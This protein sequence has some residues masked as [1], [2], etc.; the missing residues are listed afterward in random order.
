MVPTKEDKSPAQII[1]EIVTR[2][3]DDTVYCLATEKKFGWQTPIGII[4]KEEA[5]NRDFSVRLSNKNKAGNFCNLEVLGHN[6]NPIAGNMSL[7]ISKFLPD[8]VTN[9]SD[10][11]QSCSNIH[12][13][14]EIPDY[15]GKHIIQE[16]F[17]DVNDNLIGYVLFNYTDNYYRVKD[18]YFGPN[19]LPIIIAE[20]ETAPYGIQLNSIYDKNG[21]DSILFLTSGNDV[22]PNKDGAYYWQRIISDDGKGFTEK[23]IRS[24]DINHL[25]MIDEY[26]NCGAYVIMD[27]F[28]NDSISTF[29]DINDNPIT[30]PE[31]SY[32]KN[33]INVSSIK[34]TYDYNLYKLKSFEF[35]DINGERCENILGT[36]KVMIEYDSLGNETKRQGVNLDNKLSPIDDNGV[37]KYTVVWDTIGN[38]IEYHQYDFNNKPV[39]KNGNNSSYYNVYDPDTK[40]IVSKT[41]YEYNDSTNCEDI[42]YSFKYSSRVDSLLYSDKSSKVVN[43]DSLGRVT[44]TRFFDKLGNRDSNTYCAIDS[45]E[46]IL[47]LKENINK[48]IN[49]EFR[50]NGSLQSEIIIDS[51]LYTKTLFSYDES[52]H[53]TDSYQ[54]RYT[55]SWSLI[56]QTDC[57]ELGI[58]SRAGGNAGV[59]CLH[60]NISQIID[61]SLNSFEILDEFNEP[62]YLINFMGDYEIYSSFGKNESRYQARILRDEFGK[63]ITQSDFQSLRNKLPKAMSIEVVDTSAYK[64]GIRDN[65]LILCFGDYTVDLNEP[66]TESNFKFEWTVR[67]VID[68][69]KARDMVVFRVEDGKAN[70]YGLDTIAGLHGTPSEL[71]FIP[72]VR[73]LTERQTQRILE[74]LP[75][76]FPHHVDVEKPNYAIISFPEMYRSNRYTTYAENVK[77]ASILLGGYDSTRSFRYDYK[78]G[79][80]IDDLLKMTKPLKN[81]KV[82]SNLNLNYFFTKNGTNLECIHSDKCFIG[83]YLINGYITDSDWE[84]LKKLYSNTAD[85][86]KKL[87]SNVAIIDLK[88][89]EGYWEF[90]EN[91]LSSFPVAGSIRFDEDGNCLGIMTGYSYVPETK[92]KENYGSPIF[93]IDKSFNGTWEKHGNFISLN[94]NR[95]RRESIECVAMENP[96]NLEI[97]A[98]VKYFNEDYSKY[99]NYYDKRLS[100]YCGINDEFFIKSINK[101]QMVIDDGCGNEYTL[102]KAKINPQTSIPEFKGV[103]QSDLIGNWSMTESNLTISMNFMDNQSLYC[104]LLMDLPLSETGNKIGAFV[105]LGISGNYEIKDDLAYLKFDESSVVKDF[106][107]MKG[108]ISEDELNEKLSNFDEGLNNGCQDF[109]KLLIESNLSV[110]KIIDGVMYIDDMTLNRINDNFD[111]VVGEITGSEGYFVDLGLTGKFIILDWCDWNCTMDIDAFS[112]ELEKQKDNPKRITLLP[113]GVDENGNDIFGT[114]FT[115]DCPSEKLGIHITSLNVPSIYYLGTIMSRYKIMQ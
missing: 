111:V 83:M 63:E 7:T 15:S 36:H 69:S 5:R 104:L 2:H 16:R 67:N 58:P 10:Y 41:G 50:A 93:K 11:L 62:D 105:S 94:C 68:A 55:N 18:S 103:A 78:D 106:S 115:L 32:D 6:L 19:G 49:R 1:E 52:G 110:S 56:G 34:S 100:A 30:L 65:D 107:Y 48:T 87:E 71:G 95:E 57:S 91:E 85:E 70:V 37:S 73:Y 61:G 22:V 9:S 64:L 98:A 23:I 80:K 59:R 72:H 66:L 54:H 12:R 26:G 3:K 8:S 108:E 89:L 24:L 21:N 31:T 74:I 46:Y 29:I 38:V 99:S 28:K 43:Y 35:F 4:T 112:K 47:N 81:Q 92:I 97:P 13:L 109:V 17:Y 90:Q 14:I 76:S 45:T 33:Y 27:R 51:I 53:K 39:S 113:V 88:K 96:K 44:S 79:D 60:A 42:S 75:D 20:S 77:D 82:S 101:N 25:P 86:I 114:P 84:T 102:V 40:K